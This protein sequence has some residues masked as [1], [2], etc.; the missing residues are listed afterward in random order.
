MIPEYCFAVKLTDEEIKLSGE[1][2]EYS[3]ER[4]SSAR[5]MLKYA[6]NRT[7]LWELDEKIRDGVIF[8]VQ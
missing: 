4:Y 6:G 1:H 7:A 3:W 2:T 5:G 8:N